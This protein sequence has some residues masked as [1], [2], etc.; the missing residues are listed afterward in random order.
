MRPPQ[1]PGARLAKALKR[2]GFRD[3]EGCQCRSMQA[4]MDAWGSQCADHIEEILAVMR[5]AAGRPKCNPLR[6]P[7]V[8]HWARRLVLRCLK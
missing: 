1:G 8:E 4:R 3:C 2:L 7:F 6:I 5:D